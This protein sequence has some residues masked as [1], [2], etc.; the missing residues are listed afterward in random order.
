[1]GP[2]I[3]YSRSDPT[4]PAERSRLRGAFP[5]PDFLFRKPHVT[6]S[7]PVNGFTRAAQCSPT[8]PRG[9]KASAAGHSSPR[10]RSRFDGGLRL[11]CLDHLR[12]V[13]EPVPGD[14]APSL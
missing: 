9:R 10:L 14:Q 3:T 5:L 2:Y 6:G 4:S 8:P 7:S 11:E 1:M 13:V 12:R